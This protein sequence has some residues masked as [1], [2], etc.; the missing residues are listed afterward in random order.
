MKT[1]LIEIFQTIRATLQ[2]YTTLGFNDGAN[3]DQKYDLWAAAPAGKEGEDKPG[4]FFLSIEIK[5]D[6][7]AFELLPDSIPQHERTI[8]IKEL[9][10][11]TL[12]LIEDKVAAG[13]KIFK[14]HEWV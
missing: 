9:D 11:V 10:E 6:H 1:D 12:N 14:E 4:V 2:P 8:Y 13:Y 5:D 7:V 3:S